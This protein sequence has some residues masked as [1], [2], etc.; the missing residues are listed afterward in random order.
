[1]ASK[2]Q[3]QKNEGGFA[4]LMTLIV[5]GVLVSIGLAVLDLSV[6]QVRLATNAKESE[7]A[8]HAANAGVECARYWRRIASTTMESGGAISPVCF[9]A[10]TATNAV[11][12]IVAGIT[13]T[14]NVYLYDYSFSWGAKPRCTRIQT[15]VISAVSTTT[16]S[17][18]ST[19][20]PGYPTASSK[21]CAGGEKCTI[22][23]TRGYNRLCT[24]ASGYGSVEREELLQF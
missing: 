23:S 24:S 21:P 10:V 13:G 9:S 12:Q 17:N 19:V 15:L 5:V 18:M 11:T 4:L 22:I 8:F 16:V 14:G 6:K 1:M 20:I 7:T 2:F 3:Q